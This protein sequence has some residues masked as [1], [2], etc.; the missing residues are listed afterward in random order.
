MIAR[1]DLQ[2]L[3][4]SRWFIPLLAAMDE[5]GGG[6]R[7]SV[8]A[9]LLG[10]SRSALVRCLEALETRGWLERNPGHGHPLRPEYLLTREGRPIAAWCFRV[11]KQRRRLG[12]EAD[13]LGRWSLPLVLGLGPDWKRFSALE[14]ELAP[15]SPRSLSLTLKQGMGTRLVKRRLENVFPPLPLYGL[16]G[17]GRDLAAALH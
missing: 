1:S 16:T 17:R 6:A 10:I 11:M 13:M 3:C 2:A 5:L 15:I 8:L 7:F 9:R 12:L 14:T 4:A